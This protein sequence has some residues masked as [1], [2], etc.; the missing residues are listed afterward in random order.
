MSEKPLTVLLAEDNSDH[1]ELVTRSLRRHEIANR[2]YHVEDGRQAL[3][4]LLRRGQFTDPAEAPRPHVILLDLRMPKM[5]GLEV[6]KQIKSSDNLHRIPVVIL[7]TSEAD[8]DTAQAYENHVNSYLVK[9]IDFSNFS[10]MMDDLGC[11]WLRWN[12]PPSMI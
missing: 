9:P 7:T 6:L 4:F 1:A 3:D 11:Y 12:H 5:D 8:S 2:I 10:E